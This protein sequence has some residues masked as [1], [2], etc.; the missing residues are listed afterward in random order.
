MTFQPIDVGTDHDIIAPI[1]KSRGIDDTQ[2]VDLSNT[3]RAERLSRQIIANIEAC[4]NDEILKE[5]MEAETIMLDAMYLN[6]HVLW[7]DIDEAHIMQRAIF[8]ASANQSAKAVPQ[9]AAPTN[10]LGISF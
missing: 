3:M 5:Y 9:S 4:E 2:S 8:S 1:P 7:Q 10:S 6:R